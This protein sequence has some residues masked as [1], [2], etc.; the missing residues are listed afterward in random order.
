MLA[1]VQVPEVLDPLQALTLSCMS[2]VSITPFGILGLLTF[3]FSDLQVGC[4]REVST[5]WAFMSLSW[6]HIISVSGVGLI[7]VFL[8]LIVPQLLTN[9]G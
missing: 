5:V 4:D 3:C 8:V 7:A 1:H 2:E 9:S 6:C